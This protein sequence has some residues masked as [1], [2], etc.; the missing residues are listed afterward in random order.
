MHKMMNAC[1]H[2]GVK[3]KFLSTICLIALTSSE[4]KQMLAQQNLKRQTPH[5]TS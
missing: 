1:L 2:K 5:A 3:V 4:V